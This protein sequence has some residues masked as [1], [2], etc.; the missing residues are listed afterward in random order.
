MDRYKFRG[1]VIVAFLLFYSFGIATSVI[2]IAQDVQAIL[3]I[4]HVT[5]EYLLDIYF[6]VFYVVLNGYIFVFLHEDLNEKQEC[7]HR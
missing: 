1:W 4:G 5:F 7:S 6:Q 3:S 2:S